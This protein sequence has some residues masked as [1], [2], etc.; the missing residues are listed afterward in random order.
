MINVILHLVFCRFVVVFVVLFVSSVLWLELTCDVGH[1]R[2]D[3]ILWFECVRC[4]ATLREVPWCRCLLNWLWLKQRWLIF[5][6]CMGVESLRYT[7][8]DRL[9][10]W[11]VVFWVHCNLRRLELCCCKTVTVMVVCDFRLRLKNF[12]S[13]VFKL[14]VGLLRWMLDRI[15]CIP[16]VAGQL[17]KSLLFVCVNKVLVGL[18]LLL[19]CGLTEFIINRFSMH[20]V[21]A[22]SAWVH[23]LNGND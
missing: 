7:W 6:R 20:N 22:V 18:L 19:V 5:E 10:I 1:L 4:L 13:L 9:S 12:L 3:I 2:L 8:L 16:I 14:H 17:T 11:C 23:L 21:I 15:Y